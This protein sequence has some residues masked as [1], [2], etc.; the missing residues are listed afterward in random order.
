MPLPVVASVLTGSAVQLLLGGSLLGGLFY[1]Y[2]SAAVAS[3]AV[4]ELLGA[5]TA[6]SFEAELLVQLQ[7]C[8]AVFIVQPSF[9]RSFHQ[10]EKHGTSDSSA[11]V[12]ASP[13][14]FGCSALEV[15]LL[16]RCAGSGFSL[17]PTLSAVCTGPQASA[18][19]RTQ[20][21][22]LSCAAGFFFR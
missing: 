5:R 15:L 13:L 2:F 12:P 8:S 9:S 4:V 17:L 18:V 3:A 20:A 7:L 19:F 14:E 21:L 11:S 6:R 16:L 22:R 1:A 10:S